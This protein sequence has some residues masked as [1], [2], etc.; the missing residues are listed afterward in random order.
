MALKIRLARRGAKKRPFYHIVVAEATAPRDGLF[1]EKVGTYNPMVAKDSPLR[2]SLDEPRI[3]HWLS[4]G[5][6]PTDRVERFLANANLVAQ[7][8]QGNNP[9]KALPKK[10]AQDR[11]KA[12]ADAKAAAE[13][14]ARDAK[15]AAAAAAAAPAVE[16]APAEAAAE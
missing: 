16:E 7:P 8:A 4:V 11:M 3:Q 2:L 14:A 5:A 1:I 6:Q 15:E 12:E 13:Q 10:R 9:K